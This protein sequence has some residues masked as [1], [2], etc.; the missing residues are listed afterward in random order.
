MA[1]LRARLVGVLLPSR[2][3]STHLA[4]GRLGAQTPPQMFLVAL[5]QPARPGTRTAQTRTDRSP[6]A[7]RRL[8]SRGVAG[9]G[10]PHVADCAIQTRAAQMVVSDAIRACDSHRLSRRVQPLDTENRTS[11]GVGGCR[12]AIPGTRPDRQT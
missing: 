6:S 8:Q 1:A 5:A 12:G 2:G 3:A 10:Q 7:Y 4:A 9:G 11:S